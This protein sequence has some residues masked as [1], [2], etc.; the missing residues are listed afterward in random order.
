M[1]VTG[2]RVLV[3]DVG[4]TSVRASVV[5]AGAEPRRRVFATH[6]RPLPPVTPAP[7]LVEFDAAA[8]AAA[9]LDVARSALDEA[10]PVAGVGVANQRASA[11]VWDPATGRPV[12]PGLGWQDLRTVGTCLEL[13]ADGLRLAPNQTATKVA[14]LLDSH[15]GDRRSQLV[16]GTVDS[17]IIWH[18][19]GGGAHVT[20]AGNAAVTGLRTADGTAW[21]MAVGRRLGI[22]EASFPTV[23]DSAGVVA[24]AS[25]LPGAPPVAGI[26]GD[27]QAS[28]VGQGC[29]RPGLAKITFGTGA[30]LDLCTGADRPPFAGRGPGGCFPIV[31]WRR[32]GRIAWGVEAIMLSAG[33]AVDWLVDDL[34]LLVAAADSEEVAGE[35]TDTGGV[36]FVPALLGLGTPAWD[37]G[38]RG[39]LL[40][41]TRGTRRAHLV[42]AVLEG[43]AHR[44]ADLVEAAQADTDTAI[45]TLRVD[46]GMSANGCF[47]QALANACGRPVEVSPQ[48]EATTL[49]AGLLAGLGL[50]LWPDEDALAATW[51]PRATVEP[52]GPGDRDRWRAAVD[53]ARSW[54]PDLS[55]IS[56]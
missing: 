25:A 20:D 1:A 45:A 46:G 52:S 50:G 56:F 47:L 48:L 11:V 8:M 7:G 30:M 55:G 14:W 3:V 53:R 22:P 9:A 2:E 28:L 27:Q 18:L 35:V 26:A 51:A 17:W 31:A 33:T 29:T 42:R 10:G 13:Q 38:A 36:V 41:V 34:G 24:E 15:G 44:G 4:T 54:Y 43:V 16:W 12:G 21:D 39:A 6:R 49:G 19:T 40:G 5:D 32:Q 37:F 23:V